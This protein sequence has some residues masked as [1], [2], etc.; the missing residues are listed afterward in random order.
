MTITIN[1]NIKWIV[2][3]MFAALTSFGCS[4]LKTGQVDPVFEE[5]MNSVVAMIDRGQYRLAEDAL[6]SVHSKYDMDNEQ[7]FSFLMTE[8][9]LYYKAGQIKMAIFAYN[10]ASEIDNLSSDKLSEP[11]EYLAKLHYKL[12][13]YKSSAELVD[14]LLLIN[15]LLDT[16]LLAIGLSSHSSFSNDPKIFDYYVSQIMSR[17]DRSLYISDDTLKSILKAKG[18]TSY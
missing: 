7:M 2:I 1:I 15:S 13:H 18:S 8:G 16:E 6:L 9:Y 5:S 3:L 14:E 4:N 12:K 11:K 17:D 10:D